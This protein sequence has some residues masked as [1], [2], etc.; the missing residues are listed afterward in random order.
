MGSRSLSHYPKLYRDFPNRA[1]LEIMDDMQQTDSM[2]TLTTTI[3][4]QYLREIV[5]GTKK[6]EYREIKPYW[7]KRLANYEAPFL[8][9]L[10]NGMSKDAPEA[11]VEVVKVKKN[12]LLGHYELYLGRIVEVKN[13]SLLH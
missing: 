8:L 13:D 12:R 10:I 11:T 2:K 1:S 6:I 7:E 5:A 4:R 9:R 3:K